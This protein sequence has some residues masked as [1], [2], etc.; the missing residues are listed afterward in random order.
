LIRGHVPFRDDS[1]RALA[2]Q[3]PAH[4][5]DADPASLVCLP[6]RG[7]CR[8]E[9]GAQMIMPSAVPADPGRHRAGLEPDHPNTLTSRNNL[10]RRNRGN[11]RLGRGFVMISKWTSRKATV[12]W[13]R[14]QRP[15]AVIAV[16]GRRP[17]AP[18]VGRWEVHSRFRRC[19]P[20]LRAIRDQRSVGIRS[21]DC[22]GGASLVGWLDPA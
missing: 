9:N 5:P 16:L 8:G 21:G 13:A 12:R 11:E 4:A 2:P 17:A 14:H 3:R 6:V 22:R 7:L 10:C 19:S 20:R 15:N 18:P 1:P